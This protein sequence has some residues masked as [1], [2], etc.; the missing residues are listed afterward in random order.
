LGGTGFYAQIAVN[1]TQVVNLVDVSVPLA[2][3]DGVIWW[4]V[5]SAN[6]N[7]VR[8]TDPCAQLA[9][10]ALLHAIFVAIEYVAAMLARLLGALGL[11]IANGNCG[12]S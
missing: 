12:S 7:T 3:T 8:G 6:I 5:E 10:N 1:A 9:A 11:R 4:I 2:R